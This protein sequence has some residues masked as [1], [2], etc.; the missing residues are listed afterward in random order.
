MVSR[1][2]GFFKKHA[3]LVLRR[4]FNQ[5]VDFLDED[6]NEIRLRCF[7]DFDDIPS[8]EGFSDLQGKLS[9]KTTA[10]RRRIPVD[11]TGLWIKARI[12]G[13]MFDV[14]GCE[15][16]QFGSTVFNVRRRFDQQQHSNQFDL[17]GT[18]QPYL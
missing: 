1:F 10:L 18:Q 2:E 17:S 9:V 15:P 16:D 6:D 4:E 12:H 13:Q 3:A 11:E 5:F 8:G 7:V 14:Y